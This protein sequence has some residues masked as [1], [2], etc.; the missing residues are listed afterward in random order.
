MMG[1]FDGG[2]CSVFFNFYL[3]REFARFLCFLRP[4]H[5]VGI[6]PC[7]VGVGLSICL[8]FDGLM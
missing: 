6:L 1:S 2:G 7:S 4:R 3:V 8:I 5:G